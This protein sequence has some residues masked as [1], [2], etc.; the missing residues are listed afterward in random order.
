MQNIKEYDDRQLK[1]MHEILISF[2][3]NQ[4]ELSSL[5]GSLEFLLSALEAINEK[6]EEKL[7]KELTTLET[8]NA[9]EIIKDS[10]EDAPE[11]DKHKKETLITQSV[12]T[13]KKLIKAELNK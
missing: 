12:S 2:E 1:L 9:L 13:L 8:I 10:G 3:N 6:L 7:V 4:I 11:I 5:V